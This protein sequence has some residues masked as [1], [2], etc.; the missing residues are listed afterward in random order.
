MTKFNELSDTDLKDMVNILNTVFKVYHVDKESV[1]AFWECV[2]IGNIKSL[3]W[4]KNE[5]NNYNR[6]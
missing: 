2:D 5:I 6:V 1:K 3:I 4:Y